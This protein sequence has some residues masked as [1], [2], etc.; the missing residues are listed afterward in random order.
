[1]KRIAAVSTL[2]IALFLA[3]SP[4]HADPMRF[5][6]QA[7]LSVNPD[8]FVFGL[9]GTMPISSMIDF[10]PGFELGAG[11]SAF[12]I[13]LNGDL[14]VNLSTDS[15]LRP[16]VGGGLTY[17]NFNPSG[18]GGSSSNVGGSLL[19]GIWLGRKTGT[20]FFLEAKVG[21]GDVPDFK[22][23]IGLNL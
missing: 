19:G 10:A 16:Y 8:Q 9:H 22:A 4:A 11:S 6:A 20:P 3:A 1:M 14:H 17:Y 18:G 2:A 5:G 13:A 12:T 7:G 15:S 21:L 23:M